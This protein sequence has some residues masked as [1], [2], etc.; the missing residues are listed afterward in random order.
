M[1][2][3]R[4]NRSPTTARRRPAPQLLE[5][6]GV[7][8]RERAGVPSLAGP[9]T[10]RSP[11]DAIRE[12]DPS[13]GPGPRRC[14][15][16]ESRAP[17]WGP[18]LSPDRPRPG[19]TIVALR[20]IPCPGAVRDSDAAIETARSSARE[21][22]AIA[23]GDPTL[24]A[25]SITPLATSSAAWREHPRQRSHS[26]RVAR[27]HP[28]LSATG[29]RGRARAWR[30]AIG[31]SPSPLFES[32]A[33][34]G[35]ARSRAE[36]TSEW[37]SRM[38]DAR[39]SGVPC[40]SSVARVR[41]ELRERSSEGGGRHVTCSLATGE[42]RLRSDRRARGMATPI[43]VSLGRD[44]QEFKQRTSARVGQAR[45]ASG[46]ALASA[47]ARRWPALERS[48]R[49]RWRSRRASSHLGS[50]GRS[51]RR[52]QTLAG[53]AMPTGA[54]SRASCCGAE[55][56]RA[57]ARSPRRRTTPSASARQARARGQAQLRCARWHGQRARR[58]SATC[59]IAAA[60]SVR[61]AAR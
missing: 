51:S 24:L 35:Q 61:R 44:V 18:A 14:V 26:S 1:C 3:E 11:S 40:R 33:I 16:I 54:G 46:V 7:P 4:A 15:R 22:A 9:P 30:A 12:G 60:G 55:H 52:P 53:A 20:P 56:S 17:R 36:R 27:G 8:P 5:R 31:P 19:P 49:A 28:T 6:V 25:R 43:A 38:R 21:L 47:R 13:S 50:A 58:G 37:G 2:H 10:R 34:P 39:D 57:R 23:R 32:H 29:S 48:P 42:V 45:A 59:E 41:R